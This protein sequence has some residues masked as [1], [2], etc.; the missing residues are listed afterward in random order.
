[1]DPSPSSQS[2]WYDGGNAGGNMSPSSHHHL[3]FKTEIPQPSERTISFHKS[4][5]AKHSSPLLQTTPTA[6]RRRHAIHNRTQSYDGWNSASTASQAR[7]SN[8]KGG[9]WY[10][11]P[12][13]EPPP[14][15]PR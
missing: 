4:Q 1:M 6:D 14:L 11:I 2:K 3:P 8:S 15:P 13:H 5:N 9:D 7:P 12:T 10:Q